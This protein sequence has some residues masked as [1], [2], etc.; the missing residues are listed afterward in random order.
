MSER[1]TRAQL[2]ER[3][4]DC[5]MRWLEDGDRS[6]IEWRPIC[7]PCQRC[8]NEAPRI[9]GDNY[10]LERWHVVCDCYDG[11][12]DSPGR[13]D[14]GRGATLLDAIDDW[15]DRCDEART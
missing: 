1:P 9:S 8:G 11:A 2:L 5:A 3:L 10:P 6:I 14:F 7:L 15:N 12:P 13:H 4:D